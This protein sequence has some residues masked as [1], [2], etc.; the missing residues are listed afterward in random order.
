MDT[1]FNQVRLAAAALVC[2]GG[3]MMFALLIADFARF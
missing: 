3:L 1:L 2:G